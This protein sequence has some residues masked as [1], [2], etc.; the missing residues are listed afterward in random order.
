MEKEEIKKFEAHRKY[1]Q[2]KYWNDP[3]YMI[4]NPYIVATPAFGALMTAIEWNS[5]LPKPLTF[6]IGSAYA[7]GMSY[8]GY[9]V[10]KEKLKEIDDDTNKK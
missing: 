10:L 5:G 6:G 4:R 9:K 7:A 1:T 2:D 8:Y 3:K